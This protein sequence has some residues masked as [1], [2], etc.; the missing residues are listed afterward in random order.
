MLVGAAAGVGLTAAVTRVG[1]VDAHFAAPSLAGTDEAAVQVLA[2]YAQLNAQLATAPRTLTHGPR[3][4]LTAIPHGSSP[5]H[6]QEVDAQPALPPQ[7]RSAASVRMPLARSWRSHA[8]R[9][10]VSA[11]PRRA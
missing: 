1:C 8:H 6:P 2:E 7:P 5:S 9:M 4:W 11:R 3:S 10:A